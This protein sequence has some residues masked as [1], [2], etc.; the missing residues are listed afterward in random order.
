VTAA[1][2]S[3]ATVRAAI[4]ALDSQIIELIAARQAQVI[5]AGVLKR[6]QPAETVQAPARVEHVIARVRTLAED[7]GASPDV[8]EAVYRAMIGGFITL[9]LDVHRG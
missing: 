1:D 5:Q 7:A 6:G 4:D 2:T 3:L 8:V 9:E